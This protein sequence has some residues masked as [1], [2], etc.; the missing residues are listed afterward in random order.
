[1]GLNKIL[2]V[3][4]EKDIQMIAEMGL[5]DIGKIEV[6]VASDGVEALKILESWRPDLILMDVMMPNLSGVETI[7]RLSKEQNLKEIPIVLMT[8]KS[9]KEEVE[10]YKRLGVLEV[11]IKPFDPTTLAEELT[12][13]MD[14]K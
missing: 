1:M 5:K 12:K 10:E 6:K 13:L 8:A 14:K 3:E 7:K 9:E 11:I 4:D 2:I